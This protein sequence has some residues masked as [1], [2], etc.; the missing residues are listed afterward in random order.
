MQGRRI[1]NAFKILVEKREGK[2][3]PVGGRL[4]LGVGSGGGVSR[5]TLIIGVRMRTDM[6]SSLCVHFMKE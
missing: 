3:R 4:R 2:K 6:T 1:G 5:R